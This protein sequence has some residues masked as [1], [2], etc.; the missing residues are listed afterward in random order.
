MKKFLL[1]AM[2]LLASL[3]TAQAQTFSS[4]NLIVLR[5]SGY[6]TTTGD[7]AT[8]N[9]DQYTT[10]GTLVNTVAIPSSGATSLIM[11]GEPYEGYITQTPDDL[12]LVFAG[13]HSG[14][15]VQELLNSASSTVPRVIG[16]LDAHGNYAMP[17]SNMTNFNSSSING[18]A[19][20]G[21][22]YWAI[23]TGPN[24]TPYLYN[25]AVYFGTATAGSTNQVINNLAGSGMHNITLYNNAL[26]VTG[27]TTN[28][29]ISA[30]G[31]GSGGFMLSN[32]SGS[33]PTNETGWTN[34]LPTGT[35]AA[36]T[37]SDLVINSAGTI[38]YVADNSFGVVKFTNN[39][40][41]WISN[42]TILLTN[43]G[44]TIAAS[45]HAI[46]V[47]ADFTQSPTVVDAQQLQR[48]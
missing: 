44:Y 2:A 16:R 35:S 3:L 19:S 25:Q 33:L 43:T 26:Y 1:P 48:L 6:D 24:T 15:G 4:S 12:H 40:A 14:L 21:T 34:V 30:N 5:L 28:A 8:V 13:Y 31:F 38:A 11:N 27:Y 32:I 7:G 17:I 36:S 42:Y 18:A 10:N 23:G 20:D 47:T 9:M 41:G 46:S 22:N 45:G 37:S 39:G 29:G